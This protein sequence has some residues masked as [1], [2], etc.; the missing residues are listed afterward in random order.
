ML[1][2][3][4]NAGTLLIVAFVFACDNEAINKT[5]TKE[6][7]TMKLINKPIQKLELD[8]LEKV[9]GGT[10]AQKHA[11]R[12]LFLGANIWDDSPVSDI[13][14][15]FS[16]MGVL[17]KT[18]FQVKKGEINSDGE[19]ELIYISPDG[20]VYSHDDFMDYLRANYTVEYLTNGKWTE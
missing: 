18:G 15:L 20:K 9:A 14:Y 16:C 13:D 3:R 2:K 5:S 19:V 1:L 12:V 17:G 6:D 7:R 11:L 8:D 10:E 4:Q